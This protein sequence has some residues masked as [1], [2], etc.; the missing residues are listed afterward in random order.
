VG[1]PAKSAVYQIL[2]LPT[3]YIYCY[4]CGNSQNTIKVPRSVI[5]ISLCSDRFPHRC[6]KGII[7]VNRAVIFELAIFLLLSLF[8][9]NHQPQRQP[10]PT[11]LST[12]ASQQPPQPSTSPH[13]KHRLTF[14][15]ETTPSLRQ[16]R[17]DPIKRHRCRQRQ[18]FSRRA[19]SM[20]SNTSARSPG[21]VEGQRGSV[22]SNT[23]ARSQSQRSEVGGEG[24]EAKSRLTS[25]IKGRAERQARSQSGEATE[26]R[27]SLKKPRSC[28]EAW[29]RV[30]VGSLELA[31]GGESG[32]R[33]GDADWRRSSASGVARTCAFV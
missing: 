4:G 15:S 12:T 11:S 16:Q 7:R 1:K 3:V 28:V 2:V 13:H 30:G 21:R 17:R 27:G 6:L 19:A 9:T 25:P 20:I 10:P 32:R 29:T 31:V 18:G 33:K 23:S 8:W 5:P 24:S 22:I 26:L 14:V